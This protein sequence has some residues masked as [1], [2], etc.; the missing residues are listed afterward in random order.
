MNRSVGFLPRLESLRGLAAISVVGFHA[1]M[2]RS[3]TTMTGLAPVV[4][5]FVLSGFV[6]AR[7]LEN[8]S[9]PIVF[10]WSRVWRL[11]PAGAASVLLLTILYWQ[12]G[13]FVGFETDFGAINVLLNAFF[14]KSDIN[15][16][17]WSLTIECVA[18]PLILLSFIAYR[19][20]GHL[21][22]VGLFVILFALS[23]WGPYVHL[24]G[25]WTNLAPLYAFVA[26]V[27]LHFEAPRHQVRFSQIIAVAIVAAF[28][29][30]ALRKQTAPIIFAECIWSVVIIYII[31]TDER[32][33]IFSLLDTAPVRLLGRISYSFYLLHMIGLSLAAMTATHFFSLFGL[34]VAY[35]IPMAWLSWAI[36]ERPFIRLGKSRSATVARS[37][38]NRLLRPHSNI[39]AASGD[40]PPYKNQRECAAARSDRIQAVQLCSVAPPP[41][42]PVEGS[43]LQLLPPAA[44]EEG[45]RPRRTACQKPGIRTF[46]PA[47]TI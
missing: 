8:N 41:L 28:I 31:A 1:H 35:T 10:F 40:T 20:A 24:L 45:P 36:I 30:C 27:L 26:G 34:A 22:L 5:F 13:F 32:S 16:P 6:L 42:R 23:F 37:L 11:L 12:F 9:D 39:P 46:L 43:R 33:R 21:P 17:M 29:F 2:M 18:T 14:I 25:G 38:C 19:R 47:R 3:D 44:R 7:S 4:L 15:G